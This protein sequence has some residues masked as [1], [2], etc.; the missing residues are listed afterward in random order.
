MPYTTPVVPTVATVVVLETQVPPPVGTESVV[1]APAHTVAVPVM[2]PTL[3]FTVTV[4]DVR[5]PVG[6]A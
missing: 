6:S 1:L 3:E 2:L 5:Q 4:T